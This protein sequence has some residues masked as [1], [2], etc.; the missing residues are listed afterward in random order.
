[1][2][3]FY[4]CVMIVIFSRILSPVV[5]LHAEN[6][7]LKPENYT[8]ADVTS[9]WSVAKNDRATDIQWRHAK[10]V[11]VD[12]FSR[13]Q[14][15][16]A[17]ESQKAQTAQDD[18]LYRLRVVD[19]KFRFDSQRWAVGP[20]QLDFLSNE[21][22]AREPL[23]YSTYIKKFSETG[24]A[25]EYSS[26]LHAGFVNTRAD[27]HDPQLFSRIFDGQR[28]I[29]TWYPNKSAHARVTIRDS[30][31]PASVA[32]ARL[33]F[34]SEWNDQVDTLDMQAVLLAL[35]KT[36]TPSLNIQPDNLRIRNEMQSIDESVCL[37]V[38][39]I[40]DDEK[41]NFR[42]F[43][44]DP[45]AGFIIRR[46]IGSVRVGHSQSDAIRV[47]AMPARFSKSQI[48]IRYAQDPQSNWMPISWTV[49]AWAAHDYPLFAFTRSEVK[50]VDHESLDPDPNDLVIPS[51]PI[52]AW[53]IDEISGKQYVVR[54]KH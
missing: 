43:W 5:E 14:S 37:V 47:G 9:A 27:F 28:L 44:I 46:F 50:K 4:R 39:E 30:M 19:D 42:T 13:F 7:S 23:Q 18:F 54:G 41:S 33:T 48:D 2:S 3:L 35:R 6:T 34:E 21:L 49:S 40:A 53:V 11:G 15:S 24:N 38:D 31:H 36:K 45:N 16:W 10:R 8:V 20:H 26:N 32:W 52:G 17:S 25:F 22:V 51:D 29:D 1:M 12:R